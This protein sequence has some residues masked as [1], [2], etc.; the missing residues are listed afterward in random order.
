[1]SRDNIKSEEIRY[2]DLCYIIPPSVAK[3]ARDLTLSPPQPYIILRREMMNRLLLSD[4]Q[5]IQRLFQRETLGDR[6]PS[7]FLR[8]LQVVVGD[9]TVDEAVL[10][11]GW[12]KALPCYV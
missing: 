5:R 11:Q 4:S 7:Q 12:I 8:H 2:R 3:E 6:S 1:M 9:N 10:K